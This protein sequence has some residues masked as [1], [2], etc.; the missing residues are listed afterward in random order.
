MP[1]ASTKTHNTAEL[2]LTLTLTNGL[3]A[4]QLKEVRAILF[5]LADLG[6]LASHGYAPSTR[7]R[8][9]VPGLLAGAG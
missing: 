5:A 7:F 8:V 6:V 4:E 9:S 1:K 3:G 2:R